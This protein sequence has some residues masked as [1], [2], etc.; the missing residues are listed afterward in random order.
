MYRHN[1][2]KKKHRISRKKASQLDFNLMYNLYHLLSN[3]KREYDSFDLWM[4]VKVYNKSSAQ[5]SLNSNQEHFEKL[6]FQIM[7]L[8]AITAWFLDDQFF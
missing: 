6:Q 2:A 7:F 1:E 8:L 5:N 4:A 3:R